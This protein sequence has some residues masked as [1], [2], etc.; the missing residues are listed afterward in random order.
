MTHKANWETMESFSLHGQVLLP[1]PIQ[2]DS[3][4]WQGRRFQN[5]GKNSVLANNRKRKSS[6][7]PRKPSDPTPDQR[8]KK[9]KKKRCAKLSYPS[10]I[11]TGN[12]KEFHDVSYLNSIRGK[13][14][15]QNQQ[16]IIQ[17]GVSAGL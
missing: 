16:S 13:Y 4:G 9:K 5:L 6:L 7:I 12:V 8:G 17:S 2:T 10:K 14:I 15:T 3:Y 11:A 1:V